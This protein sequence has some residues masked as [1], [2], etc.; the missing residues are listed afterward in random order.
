MKCVEVYIPLGGPKPMTEGHG[1]MK[2]HLSRSEPTLRD[3]SH[4]RVPCRTERKPPSCALSKI[5]LLLGLRSCFPPPTAFPWEHSPHISTA[6]RSSEGRNL[7]HQVQTGQARCTLR[8]PKEQGVVVPGGHL[9]SNPRKNTPS[10]FP[11]PSGSHRAVSKLP[12]EY[13]PPRIVTQ[14]GKLI[15]LH[16]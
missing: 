14:E 12:P 6:P 7:G 11:L 2:A 9:S 10:A 5:T 15:W 13:P 3:R 16:A 4:P 1:G 8:T